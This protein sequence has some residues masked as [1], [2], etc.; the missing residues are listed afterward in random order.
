M[1]LKFKQLTKSELSQICGGK[2]INV[3]GKWIWVAEQAIDDLGNLLKDQM[4]GLNK[5]MR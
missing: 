5:S 1:N 4:S 3:D 2:W